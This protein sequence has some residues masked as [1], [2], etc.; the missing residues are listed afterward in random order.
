MADNNI[1]FWLADCENEDIDYCRLFLNQAELARAQRFKTELLQRRFIIAR[2]MLKRILARYQ[3]ISAKNLVFELSPYGK[4]FISGQNEQADLAFNISHSTDKLV[5]VVA[6]TQRL[7]VDIE[8]HKSTA[9]LPDLVK[10]CFAKSEQ[11]YWGSLPKSS[12]VINFYNIWTRKEAFV[13]AVGRG[14]ALGLNRCVT[15]VEK[16]AYWLAIPT[17]YGLASAWKT[18]NTA[19]IDGFSIAVVTNKLSAG[20]NICTWNQ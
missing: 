18:I 4:P 2:A 7:G 11:D 19:V 15:S 1:D 10:K 13:K 20:L 12:Q 16:P 9:S 14:I 5:V 3:K 17:E 6:K 8:Q